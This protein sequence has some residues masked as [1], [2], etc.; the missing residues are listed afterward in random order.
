VQ[1]TIVTTWTCLLFAIV[2]F[3]GPANAAGD[4]DRGEALFQTCAACHSIEP[5]VNKLGPTLFEVV[6]RKAAS[7]A[8]FRYSP[9][10]QQLNTPWTP[11]KITQFLAG[12]Q[13]MVPG[14]TMPIG[15][16]DETERDDIVAYLATLN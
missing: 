13:T 7:V 11:D 14:T 5:G 3:S 8:G 12:P 10:L 16:G 2:L 6:G 15:V 1:G 4:A 9:A